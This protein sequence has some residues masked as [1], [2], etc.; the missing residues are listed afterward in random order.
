MAL[1]TL[2]SDGQVSNINDLDTHSRL[3]SVSLFS[4]YKR[5]YLPQHPALGVLVILIL[6]LLGRKALWIKFASPDQWL[7]AKHFSVLVLLFLTGPESNLETFKKVECYSVIMMAS[8]RGAL[9]F[10][11]CFHLND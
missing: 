1:T 3:K 4:V 11:K 6:K 7:H 2:Q 8:T 5:I 10:V 9:Y